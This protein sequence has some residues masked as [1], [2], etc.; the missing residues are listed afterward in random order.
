MAPLGI[1][2]T[3]EKCLGAKLK[4]SALLEQI[5]V[6]LAGVWNQLSFGG[7]PPGGSAWLG[8]EK[9][10]GVKATAGIARTKS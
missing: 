3:A 2:A 9:G 5:R 10:V 8:F 1:R 4:T 6:H 7:V